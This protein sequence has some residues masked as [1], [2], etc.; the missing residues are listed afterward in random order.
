MAW[1]V[2]GTLVLGIV[3]AHLSKST[4]VPR[5]ASV[6]FVPLVILMAVGTQAIGARWLRLGVIAILAVTLL[7]QGL[8]W[9]TTQRSQAGQVVSV[10]SE[11][12]KPGDFVLFCP[13]QLGPAVLRELPA[14][15]GLRPLAYP[16]L[17]DPHFI[18][19]V[20]YLDAI[21]SMTPQRFVK[22][23]SH[24]VHGHSVWLVWSTGYGP[25]QSTCSFVASTF[26]TSPGWGGHQ[27]VNAHPYEYFQSMNLTQFN[28]P[29]RPA[30]RTSGR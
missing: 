16:R 27:W 7:I 29:P 6:I 22:E 21:K 11:Q 4:F 13:D 9:R 14:S 24:R 23:I 25:F 26:L 15:T 8:E 2:F 10:L 17:D 30:R 28:P 1:V 20:D 18:N 3:G 5:Y 19:W 12:A